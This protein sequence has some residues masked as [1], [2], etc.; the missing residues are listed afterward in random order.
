[1]RTR[2]FSGSSVAR[3]SSR[4]RRALAK[5]SPPSTSD[6]IRSGG[7][8][9]LEAVEEA[10]ATVGKGPGASAA[11]RS[12]RGRGS[13]GCERLGEAQG[14]VRVQLEAWRSRWSAARTRTSRRPSRPS[15][16]GRP[17]AP[18]RAGWTLGTARCASPGGRSARR[19]AAPPARRTPLSS[20]AA[21][22]SSQV[23]ISD[24]RDPPDG[25]QLQGVL[26][27]AGV[28]VEQE[29][30]STAPQSAEVLKDM[31]P[32]RSAAPR[33]APLDL[34]GVRGGAR[35]RCRGAVARAMAA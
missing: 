15:R 24:C 11:P 23:V 29:H 14:T 7:A 21:T 10:A 18:P 4:A 32:N 1:M 8:L 3:S 28:E 6:A 20:T 30:A 22:R 25:V 5:R 19:A 26:Q 33:P 12:P 31:G 2:P 17:R 35:R 13:G 27:A 9:D 34:V 16:S